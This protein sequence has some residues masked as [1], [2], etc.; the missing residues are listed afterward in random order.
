MSLREGRPPLEE[1]ATGSDRVGGAGEGDGEPGKESFRPG[2]LVGF[3]G[4]IADI[5]NG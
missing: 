5:V 3:G 1:D 2:R 4:R